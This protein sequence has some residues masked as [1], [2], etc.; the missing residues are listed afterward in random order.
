MQIHCSFFLGGGVALALITTII[1]K[2]ELE[3]VPADRKEEK[4]T[5]KK[6]KNQNVLKHP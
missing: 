2:L 4:W 3:L 1:V 5:K 6:K